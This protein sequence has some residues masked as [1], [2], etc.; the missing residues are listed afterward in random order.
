MRDQTCTVPLL[1]LQAAPYNWIRGD[2]I[3]AKVSAAN[4]W[5]ESKLSTAGNGATIVTIPS[6]PID[7]LNNALVTTDTRIGFTWSDGIQTGGRPITEYRVSWDRASGSW[8]T[9]ASG[10]TSKSYTTTATLIAG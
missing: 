5:G 2:S 7:L 6:P 4:V 9:L 3:Y 8:V 1:V 10:L